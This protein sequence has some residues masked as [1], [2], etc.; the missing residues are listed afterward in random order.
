LG[1][2][3]FRCIIKLASSRIQ[4]QFVFSQT[5]CNVPL[6]GLELD[7]KEAVFSFFFFEKRF[8]SII[9]LHLN[10]LNMLYLLFEVLLAPLV[11]LDALLAGCYGSCLS[12]GVSICFV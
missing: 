12:E 6:E 1:G 3:I 2:K 5:R 11:R 9:L 8:N 10:S 7:S 4:S